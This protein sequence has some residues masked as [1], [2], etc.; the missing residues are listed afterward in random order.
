MKLSGK[1]RAISILLMTTVIILSFVLPLSAA[2]PTYNMTEQY[3]ASYYYDNFEIVNLSG[4]QATDVLAVAL[5][6]LGY[7]EGD[8]DDDLGGLN[9]SGNKNFVEYNVLYG[10]L[11]NNEGNGYSY[12]YYWCAAFVNWCLREAGVSTEQTAVGEVSCQR[13]LRALEAKNMY[14]VAHTDKGDYVPKSGD[15]IFFKSPSSTSA[16][17]H[18]GIVRY[19]DEERVY[20]IE[21]NTSNDSAFSSN[22]NYVCIKSYALSDTLIVGYGIPKYKKNSDVIP[23]D[24]SG[25]N[26]TAGLY[27]NERKTPIYKEQNTLSEKVITMELFHVFTVTEVKDSWFKVNF[28]QDGKE[29]TGWVKSSKGLHQM[30]AT[31]TNCKITYSASSEYVLNMPDDSLFSS[32]SSA[33]VSDKIPQMTNAKF[34]GWST[35]KDSDKVEY[36]PLDVIKESGDITLYAVWD[37]EKHTVIFK[38]DNNEIIS[39]IEGFIGD[40]I[41]IPQIESVR[42]GKK[43]QGWSQEVP[44]TIQGAAEFTAIYVADTDTFDTPTEEE[45][46]EK[47]NKSPINAG[48]RSVAGSQLFIIIIVSAVAV[49]S[50]KK[51]RIKSKS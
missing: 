47:D 41:D 37:T 5:S 51:I 1:L 4:N 34:L 24:Y 15:L 42:E 40:K 48:C 26:K 22:G 46:T 14:K 31:D 19:A 17:S 39:Q 13:W 38:Y 30:T 12:G 9:K 16:S 20:T 27:I 44:D 32:S 21:G 11:D 33:T 18:I 6:Q 28:K 8:S 45:T 2:K 50:F 10:K 35:E 36:K 3:K 49:L 7:H 25:Q 43:F 29:Y 23:V